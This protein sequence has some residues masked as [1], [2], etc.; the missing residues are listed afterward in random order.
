MDR[1]GKGGEIV[2]EDESFG[3]FYANQVINNACGTLAALNA[4]SRSF[5]DGV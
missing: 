5:D 3:V 2:P 4:V 1:K